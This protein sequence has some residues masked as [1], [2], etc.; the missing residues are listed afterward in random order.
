[1]INLDPNSV[2]VIAQN[3]IYYPNGTFFG[4]SVELFD[5][6]K[7]FETID[8]HTVLSGFQYQ[9]FEYAQ[10][11][12]FMQ[13]LN[14]T[15]SGTIGTIGNPNV[16]YL[17]D[18]I[19]RNM[20][21]MNSNWKII[22]RPIDGWDTDSL[23]W[24][25]VCIGIAV[26]LVVFI[27]VILG[28]NQLVQDYFRKKEYQYIQDSLE[29][30]V[31]ER[32]KDLASSHSQLLLLLDR[33]SFEEQRTKKIMNSLE[34]SVITIDSSAMGKIIHSNNAFFKNFGYTDSDLIRNLSIS[35]LLPKL[36]LSTIV[37]ELKNQADLKVAETTANTKTGVSLNV[38]VS[39]SMSQIYNQPSNNQQNSIGQPGIPTITITDEKEREMATIRE[40]KLQTVYVILIHILD[41]IIHPTGF[42]EHYQLTNQITNEFLEFFTDIENR[43]KFKEFC[44]TERNDENICFL[45][46]VEFYKSLGNIQERVTM[47]EEMYNKYLKANSPKQLNISKKQ[48]ETHSF[49]I[50]RGLGEFELFDELERTVILTVSMD[51][52]KRWQEKERRNEDH[53]NYL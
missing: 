43:K 45:E 2:A 14:G 6:M 15:K 30:K 49:K 7:L 22:L 20:T 3:P 47:Q 27:L 48:L 42:N 46:D 23:L 38:K 50:S 19:E 21:V 37:T 9:L 5:F 17:T 44:S 1:M 36:N 34:D 35:T 11:Q 4:L 33:I 32:T 53:L 28:V 51:S 26:A 39:I 10:N 24:L 12:I 52:F 13:N 40:C 8:L 16:K 31:K 25:E 41:T 29:M 18:S